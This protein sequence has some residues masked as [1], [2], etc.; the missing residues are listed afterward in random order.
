[1]WSTGFEAI[2]FLSEKGITREG[3]LAA[4]QLSP[5]DRE[6]LTEEVGRFR[7]R[8]AECHEAGIR[9]QGA[10]KGLETQKIE[11]A[12]KA[13]TMECR[14]KMLESKD[15]LLTRMS[16]DGA[17]ALATWMLNERSKIKSLIPKADLEFYRLPR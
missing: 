17:T 4:L 8:R 13:N 7:E 2:A 10:M 9:I 5:A 16:S 3:P 14:I 11:E 6:M 12:M 1:M 15:R